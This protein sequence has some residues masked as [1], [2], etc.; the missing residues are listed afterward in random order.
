MLMILIESL[1][2]I[3]LFTAVIVSV[4]LKN[5]LTS[6]G[7]YPPAIKKRCI[8]LGLIEDGEKRYTKADYI[9]KGVALIAVAALLA[10]VVR[11]FNG[12]DTF[13]EGFGI[14]YLIWLIIDWYDALVLDCIWFCHSKRVRIPGTEEM[15]EYKDYLFHIKGSCIGMLLGLPACLLVGLFVMLL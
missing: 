7:D 10:V 1:I 5:P 3:V 14:S 12:A 11:R 9:R 15:T 4:T 6:V 13:L 8:E 2:G